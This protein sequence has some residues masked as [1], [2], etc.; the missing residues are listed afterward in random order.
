MLTLF[1]FT[2]LPFSSA[3]SAPEKSFSRAARWSSYWQWLERPKRVLLGAA[4]NSR[5]PDSLLSSLRLPYT[6]ELRYYYRGF[7]V[8]LVSESSRQPNPEGTR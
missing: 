4:W 1:S 3:H 6:P 5:D 8:V 7:R 2:F